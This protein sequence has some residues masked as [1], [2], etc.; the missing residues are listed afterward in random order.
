MTLRPMRPNIIHRRLYYKFGSVLII[1]PRLN[2]KFGS[3]FI[4][5]PTLAKYRG[6]HCVVTLYPPDRPATHG[7][8][9]GSR[10]LMCTA[11]TAATVSAAG[12]S[13]CARDDRRR[14]GGGGL[15]RQD[16]PLQ[17]RRQQELRYQ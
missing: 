13:S 6:Q 5:V 10:P 7:T 3:I 2:Y 11:S 4:I 1:V 9:H 17:R 8:M 14:G 12:R 16:M 15:A